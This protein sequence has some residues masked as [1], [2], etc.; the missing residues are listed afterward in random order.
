M[1]TEIYSV[2]RYTVDLAVA[3]A[4]LLRNSQSIFFFGAL[5]AKIHSR[6]AV[7]V[8]L[9]RFQSSKSLF[10]IFFCNV[11]FALLLCVAVDVGFFLQ[12]CSGGL[13]L[14]SNS[15]GEKPP[16]FNRVREEKTSFL[17]FFCIPLLSASVRCA[18]FHL[19]NGTNLGCA[20]NSISAAAVRFCS[21]N[22]ERGGSRSV[23]EMSYIQS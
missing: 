17:I 23:P 6:A 8:R 11:R 1:Y 4:R 19:S 7:F 20:P 12:R 16:K 14:P 22:R 18:I 3:G 10:C 15:V 2:H 9:V 5:W 13:N 21:T